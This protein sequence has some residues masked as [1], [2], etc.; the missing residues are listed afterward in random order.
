MTDAATLAD[1]PTAV[2]DL[3]EEAVPGCWGCVCFFHIL[4]RLLLE[5]LSLSCFVRF[6]LSDS[7]NDSSQQQTKTFDVAEKMWKGLGTAH[8]FTFLT[9]VSPFK[10][11]STVCHL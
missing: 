8:K 9:N 5:I 7:I 6:R 10:E 3:Q 2:C 11:K 1:D 4:L